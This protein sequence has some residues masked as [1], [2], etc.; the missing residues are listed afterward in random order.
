MA[1]YHY[2]SFNLVTSRF[3][4]TPRAFEVITVNAVA[5]CINYLLRALTSFFSIG[6]CH[7]DS[8]IQVLFNSE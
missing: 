3:T 7:N 6:N 4:S 8:W 2:R 1:F 5:R